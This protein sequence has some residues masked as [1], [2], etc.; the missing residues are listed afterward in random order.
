MTR[1]LLLLATLGL[2]AEPPAVQAPL[3]PAGLPSD[4]KDHL[5]LLQGPV[6]AQEI[7]AHRTV[8]RDTLAAAPVPAGLR[9]RWKAVRRPFTL[10]AVF[11]SWCGDSHYHLPD[12]LGLDADPNPFIEVRYLGVHR[13]KRLEPA[14]WPQGCPPQAVVRVPT[15]F[16]F[17]TEPGGG[18]RLVGSVVENPPRA[19]QRMAEALV[20]LVEGAARP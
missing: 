8:F 16:L 14:Q 1:A 6:S 11:G 18:Q 9:D 4:P 17:A 5:P 20:D 15:F 3:P 2:A 19:G 10:V 12:L 13:D 7:L